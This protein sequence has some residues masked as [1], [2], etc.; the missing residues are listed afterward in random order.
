VPSFAKAGAKAIV[1]VARNSAQLQESAEALTQEYP[2]TKFLPLTC[3]IKDE[4]SV[5]A[6]FRQIKEAFGTADVLVNNAGTPDDV[7]PLRH[8]NIDN[9]WH[10]IVRN[11]FHSSG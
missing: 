6:V 1:L 9:L 11:E 2:N 3:D 7:K 10:G 4:A 8:A 5:R